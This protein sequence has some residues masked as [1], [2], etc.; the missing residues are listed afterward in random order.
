MSSV[1]GMDV[2]EEAVKYFFLELFF[3]FGDH[4]DW[5]F[6]VFVRDP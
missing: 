5:D 3:Y 6:E 2:Y 1:F 4:I